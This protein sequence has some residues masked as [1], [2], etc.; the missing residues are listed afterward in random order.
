MIINI[1]LYKM[2]LIYIHKMNN[3]YP[4]DGRMDNFLF[5]ITAIKSP[6]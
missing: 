4:V 3:I 6:M 2:L 1:L 5:N